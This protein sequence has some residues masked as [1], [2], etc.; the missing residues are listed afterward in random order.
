MIKYGNTYMLFEREPPFILCHEKFK[1]MKTKFLSVHNA[2]LIRA[3][4]VFARNQSEK[5]KIRG[6]CGS[7]EKRIEKAALSVDGVSKAD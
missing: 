3:F 7:C 6:N 1:K 2:V 4:T 5:S